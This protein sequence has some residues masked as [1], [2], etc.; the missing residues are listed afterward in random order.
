MKQK[1]LICLLFLCLSGVAQS[2]EGIYKNGN[3]N[4]LRFLPNDRVEFKLLHPGGLISIIAGEGSYERTKRKLVIKV[5]T[6]NQS[7][8]SQFKELSDST[9]PHGCQIEVTT[10]DV[11]NHLLPGVTLRFKNSKNQYQGSESNS[12]GILEI[13]LKEKPQSPIE[14]LKLGFNPA[15]LPYREEKKTTYEVIFKEENIQFIDNKKLTVD[16]FINES[17]KSFKYAIR[18]IE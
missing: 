3:E 4:Y 18:K 16:L 6:H 12:K 8:E 10:R 15:F 1:L 14:L 5:E 2:L 13:S 9:I 17:D 11:M 7:Y